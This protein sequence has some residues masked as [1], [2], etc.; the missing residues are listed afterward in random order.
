MREQKAYTKLIDRICG[1][2]D[3]SKMAIGLG[4]WGQTYKQRR[5]V[6]LPLKKLF[7]ELRKRFGQRCRKVDEYLTS[8]TCSLCDSR[9]VAN[10]LNAWSLRVCTR[11]TCRRNWNRDVNASRNIRHIMQYMNANAGNRPSEFVSPFEMSFAE[12]TIAQRAID[13]SLQGV[14]VATRDDQSLQAVYVTTRDE[15][16]RNPSDL[17]AAGE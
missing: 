14:Y 6:N 1:S 4:D 8:Q 11:T 12:Q 17:N 3:R 13:L 10:R 5:R 9:L 15:P 16:V 7:G 2:R